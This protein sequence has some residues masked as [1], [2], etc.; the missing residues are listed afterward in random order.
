MKIDETYRFGSFRL[1]PNRREL[2]A[3]DRRVAI[4]PR[5]FDVLVLLVRRAGELVTK[6]ELIGAVWSGATVED[7]AIAAQVAAVRR[8][9]GR[10]AAFIETAPGRGYRFIMDVVTAERPTFHPRTSAWAKKGAG[11][12]F[13]A[14]GCLLVAVV[15]LLFVA[16]PRHGDWRIGDWETIAGTFPVETDPA[17]TPSGGVIAFAAGPERWRRRIYVQAIPSGEP[18]PITKGEGDESAPSWSPRGDALAFVRGREDR[19][20]EILVRP[21][22]GGTERSVG[23]CQGAWATTLVWSKAGDALFFVDRPPKGGAAA[24]WRMT[25]DSGAVSRVTRPPPGSDGDSDVA[26]SPDG[27]RLSFQ[28]DTTLLTEGVIH[29]LA[30]GAERHALSKTQNYSSIAWADDSTLLF[31]TIAPDPSALWTQPSDGGPSRRLTLN[32]SEF[33]RLIA[34]GAGLF[35]FETQALRYQLVYGATSPDAAPEVIDSGPGTVNGLSFA[36]NGDLTFTHSSGGM[37]GWEVWVKPV[38]QIARAITHINAGY[39]E[40]P[41]W[42]PDRSMIAFKATTGVASGIWVVRHDGSALRRITRDQ[43]ETGGGAWTPD[44][45]GFVYMRLTGGLWSLW[46]ADLDGKSH[47]RALYPGGWI[48]A[49]SDGRDLY[50]ISQNGGGAWRLGRASVMVAPHLSMRHSVDWD[51]GSGR[52]TYLDFTASGPARLVVHSFAGG[53]DKVFWA[54]HPIVGEQLD[55]EGVMGGVGFDPRAGR[56]VYARAGDSDI[57]VGFFRLVKQ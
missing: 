57:R 42:S 47:E 53:A 11:L 35:G 31:A 49:R 7:N 20:C 29:D 30:T 33:R 37:A 2:L 43:A 39:L 14:V 1:S 17:P 48:T 21:F 13:V 4:G 44:G 9:L 32:P 22:P 41:T 19:P 45:R 24:V 55:N 28:R 26:M 25:I 8:A 3:S 12:K 34:N 40:S 10:D 52:L 18:V 46:R 38:G 16:S 51:V 50:S 15:V 6:D 56:P 54:S 36:D 23:A 5:A 27:R